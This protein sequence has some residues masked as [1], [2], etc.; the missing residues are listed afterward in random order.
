MT[1]LS[2]ATLNRQVCLISANESPVPTDRKRALR[3]Y[4]PTHKKWQQAPETDTP[5]ILCSS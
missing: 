1:I 5:A 3:R 2:A 4:T